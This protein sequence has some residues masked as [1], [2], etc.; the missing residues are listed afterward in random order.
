MKFI[1]FLVFAAQSYC[2]NFHATYGLDSK[3]S[4]R[5]LGSLLRS[6]FTLSQVLIGIQNS[7]I[8]PNVSKWQELSVLLCYQYKLPNVRALRGCLHK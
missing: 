3:E 6:L 7:A 8:Y 2:I 5:S 4:P 1:I